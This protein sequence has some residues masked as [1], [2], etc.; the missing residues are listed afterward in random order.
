MSIPAWAVVLFVLEDSPFS[1]TV[2][3]RISN[4]GLISIPEKFPEVTPV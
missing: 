3:A 1:V 2:P 4:P